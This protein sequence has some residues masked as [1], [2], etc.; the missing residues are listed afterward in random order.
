[1]CVEHRVLQREQNM[2]RSDQATSHFRHRRQV[3]RAAAA[4]ALVTVSAPPRAEGGA[5]ALQVGGLP[6]TC[7]LTLPVACMASAT[8]VNAAKG[9]EPLFE[10]SKYSGWP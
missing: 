1:M 6:V 4:A 10:F 7:N 3:L 2:K 8:D 9:A 5:K